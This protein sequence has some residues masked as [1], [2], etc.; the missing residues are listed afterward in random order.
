MPYDAIWCHMMS[1]D[2]IWCHMMAYDGIWWHMMAFCT[3]KKPPKTGISGKLLHSNHIILMMDMSYGQKLNGFGRPT[4][5]S[6]IYWLC[7]FVNDRHRLYFSILKT[8][9]MPEIVLTKVDRKSWRQRIIDQTPRQTTYL[10]PSFAVIKLFF[11]KVIFRKVIQFF[12]Q[13]SQV[14]AW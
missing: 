6:I 13:I 14:S 7:V 4:T 9:K 12:L 11:I 8:D 3:Q 1:Y 10:Y 2:V 5:S